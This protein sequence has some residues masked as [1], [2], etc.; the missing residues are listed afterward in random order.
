[1]VFAVVFLGG[2]AASSP[3]KNN[4]SNATWIAN[5]TGHG[6]QVGHLLSGLALVVSGVALL[7]FMTGLWRRVAAASTTGAPSPLPVVA[8]AT[9]AAC[10]AGGG[11]MMGWISGTELSGKFPLPS[12]DL[13]RMSNTLGFLMVGIAAMASM[14]VALIGIAVQAHAVGLFGSKMR[15]ATIVVGVVLAAG[16]A[17]IPVILLVIW[18]VVVAIYLLRQPII[19]ASVQAVDSNLATVG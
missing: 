14:L 6:H 11:L 13:L 15:T 8:A 1:L 7:V 4:A 2:V 17:F 3:P 16:F 12:A 5:Y 18:A 19:V 10:F 9:A